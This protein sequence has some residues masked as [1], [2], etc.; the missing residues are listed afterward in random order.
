M[1]RG[2]ATRDSDARPSP[3]PSPFL[4]LQH[5]KELPVSGLVVVD[6]GLTPE[7]WLFLS[8]LATLVLF[9]KFGRILSIR[10]LDLLLLFAPAP[11]LMRL[12]G[13][14]DSQPWWAF[15]WLFLGSAL[16]FSRCL[17]DLGLTRRPLLEPNL[18]LGGLAVLTCGMLGLILAETMNLTAMEGS[19]RNPA[20]PHAE[21][22]D[23][24]GEQAS[25]SASDRTV[26][27]V[28]R[29]APHPAPPETASGGSGPHRSDSRPDRRR[30]DSFRPAPD[31]SGDGCG[32]PDLAVLADRRGGYRPAPALRA[33]RPGDPCVPPP[34]A[35]RSPGGPGGQLDARRDCPGAALVRLFPGSRRLAVPDFLRRSGA[36]RSRFWP[37]PFPPSPNGPGPW[38][39][40]AWPRRVSC[41]VWP[42]PPREVSGPGWI[43]R[44]ACRC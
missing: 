1:I 25:G 9:F 31:R 38:V 23:N 2:L 10:N 28:L 29:Q 7:V 33:H 32:V 43:P 13:S 19:A 16:W 17:V 44:T 42:T 26:E 8:M 21:S 39:L 20:E 11:G 14:G 35:L 5:S 22:V 36:D 34:P 12:V 27:R 6:L 18:N 15:V 41:P 40:A 30:L 4:R 24:P 37:F 3:S